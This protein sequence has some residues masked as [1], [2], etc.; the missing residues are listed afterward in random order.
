M[1]VGKTKRNSKGRKT[2]QRKKTDPMLRKEWYDVVAPVVFPT[3]VASKTLANRSHGLKRAEDNL[4]GRVFEANHADLAEDEN[5]GY[6][7]VLLRV[8]DV[9]GRSCI[10]NFHGCDLT[11][12]KLK[13]MIR[14]RC[15]LIET[16]VNVRTVDGFLLRVFVIAFTKKSS[17]KQI[18]RNCYAQ[19]RQVAVIRKRMVDTVSKEKNKKTLQ[20]GF[21]HVLQE[22]LAKSIDK[23]CSSVYPLRDVMIRKVKLLKMP[24]FDP[25]KLMEA[26]GGSVP[27]SREEIGLAA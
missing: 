17:A 4:K 3:R 8:D 12:D 13:G 23:A 25:A 9:Q 27:A 14:K 24:K 15:T 6:R 5:Y 18:K 19:S 10:T 1:V 26:H 22:N 11:C 21:K 7:K 20:E 16:K 2:T